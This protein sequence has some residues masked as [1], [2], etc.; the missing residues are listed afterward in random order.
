MFSELPEMVSFFF[1]RPD[2]DVA[3]LTKKQD[4]V[5]VKQFLEVAL[6]CLPDSDD[7]GMIEVALRGAVEKHGFRVG[8]F[9]SAIRVGITGRTAAPGLF[10]TIATL[11]VGEAKER[12]DRALD[13]LSK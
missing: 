4:P 5:A 1:R 11:G 9:F 2:V 8:D 6:E 13:T 12:L 7:E 10:E 3:L